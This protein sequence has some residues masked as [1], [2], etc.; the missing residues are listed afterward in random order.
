[1]ELDTEQAIVRNDFPPRG[2]MLWATFSIIP[3][4]LQLG[5]APLSIASFEL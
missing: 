4:E 3:L 2:E 1:M 5:E